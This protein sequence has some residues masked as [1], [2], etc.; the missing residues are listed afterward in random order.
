MSENVVVVFS[1]PEVAFT[2]TVDVLGVGE[3]DPPP[4][5]LS[6]LKPS[7][8]TASIGSICKYRFFR[9]RKHR[10]TAK[11]APGNSGPE[12]RRMAPVVLDEETVSIVVT[13]APA[14]VG[15]TVAGEKLHDAPGGNPE[16]L[17][18]T[19]ESKPFCGTTDTVAG[20]PLCP[21]ATVID[22]GLIE[23]EKSGAGGGRLMV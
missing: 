16:Q 1:D 19:A 7:T 20:G 5:P 9:P 13:V 15:V 4:H 12:S 8:L 23:M 2:V 22:V 11:I 21:D 6:T 18:E 3:D 14:G 17:K 10:A